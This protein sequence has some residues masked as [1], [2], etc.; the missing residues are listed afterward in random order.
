MGRVRSGRGLGLALTLGL[1]SSGLTTAPVAAV[2]EVTFGSG[3]AVGTFGQSVEFTQ[4]VTL[5]A[6]P[7]TVELLITFADA[8]GP[9]VYAIEPPPDGGA[10]ILSYSLPI[11]GGAHLLPNT[12]LRYRWRVDG[13]EG[14]AA[15]FLLEDDRFEWRTRSG[16]LVRVHWYDGD[17]AF[18]ERALRIGEAAIE[19]SS[20]LLGVTETEPVDFFV[21]A[22]QADF[23]DALGPGTRENVGGQANADIRTLFALITPSEIDDPW[24]GIVIPHELQHLVFNTAV[25]NP[26]HFPPRWLNE[27]LA[28]YESE[29]G[30]PAADRRSVERAAEA[31]TLIPLTGL[32]GQ[33]PTTADGFGLAYAESVSAVDFLIRTHTKEALVGLVRSYADGLTDDEAFEAAIG[34]DMAAFSD[35]WLADIGTPVPQRLGPQPAPPG[36][37]PPGWSGDGG[38]IVG[39]SAGPTDPGAVASATPSATSPGTGSPGAG[40]GDQAPALGVLLA[41]G[42]IVF[43]IGLV[44][45]YRRR[46]LDA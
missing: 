24:V 13:V 29:G 28:V 35:A 46:D 23:R 31:G 19:A 14:P 15:R 17:A 2:D 26:Y 43:G 41:I 44:A 22:G 9:T 5:S 45:A 16:D 42:A 18:G 30:Y 25:R 40:S 3:S 37:V 39:P 10:Q 1:L 20:E 4:A 6:P 27:G 8:L 36:P 34:M 21:Y 12:P 7:R 11:G 33:F 38:P 32:T